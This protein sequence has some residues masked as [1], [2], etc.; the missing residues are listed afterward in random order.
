MSV[1]HL[2][3]S[4]P[5]WSMAMETF[6]FH[7]PCF[8]LFFGHSSKGGVSMALNIEATWESAYRTERG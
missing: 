6:E 1:T 5:I 3:L 8:L 7:R 2:L 4:L